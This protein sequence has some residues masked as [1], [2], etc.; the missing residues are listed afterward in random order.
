MPKVKDEDEEFY[1]DL[2]LIE[3]NPESIEA[4]YI[5]TIKSL[6]SL[7]QMKV[8]FKECKDKLSIKTQNFLELPHIKNI[9]KKFKVQQL[10]IKSKYDNK[11]KEL[12][13]QIEI[14]SETYTRSVCRNNLLRLEKDRMLK[15]LRNKDPKHKNFS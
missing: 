1:Q 13:E 5:E 2:L 12:N 8:K 15:F 6:D 11:M 10:G 9:I 7:D 14:Q 4:Q 3:H